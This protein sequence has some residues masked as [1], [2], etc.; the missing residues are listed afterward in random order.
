MDYEVTLKQHCDAMAK[1]WLQNAKL[2]LE[3]V[4]K[5]GDDMESSRESCRKDA[6]HCIGKALEYLEKSAK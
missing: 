1:E 4:N 5:Y 3:K 6:V 2:W